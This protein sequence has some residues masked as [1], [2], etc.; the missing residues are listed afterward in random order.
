MMSKL[1]WC[2]SVAAA[3]V[4]LLVTGSPTRL[5]A[6]QTSAE[7]VRIGA[8][9]LGGTVA[10]AN[11]PEAGVWVI[12][13]TTQ[14]PTQFRRIVVTDGQGRYLVPDL[15]Q[16]D[17]SVFV[18][19]YGLVELAKDAREAGTAARSLGRTGPE[20]GGCGALLPR[21]LLVFTADDPG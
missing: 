6:Q 17:Y 10:G 2:P 15:P 9:D 18:R 3:A 8:N 13:E 12:A 21:D 19:G 1:S 14:L 16:A 5:S 4:A 11:G 20:R 7:T